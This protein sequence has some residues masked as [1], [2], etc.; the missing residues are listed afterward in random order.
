MG[1]AVWGNESTCL[2]KENIPSTP[3][4]YFLT[5]CDSLDQKVDLVMG[6]S[7]T[8]GISR[9]MKGDVDDQDKSSSTNLTTRLQKLHHRDKYFRLLAHNKVSK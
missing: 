5:P 1:L 2:F 7:R 8:L 4:Y 6:I 3:T 9:N